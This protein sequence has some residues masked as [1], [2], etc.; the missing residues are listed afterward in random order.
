MLLRTV[1]GELDSMQLW[2]E[3]VL[4]I[5]VAHWDS[6]AD[7]FDAYAEGAIEAWH[8]SGQY[9]WMREA[10]TLGALV[11]TLA[12]VLREDYRDAVRTLRADGDDIPRGVTG[13]VSPGFA[14]AVV[15]AEITRRA[16]YQRARN[17]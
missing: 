17:S 16:L 15:R 1:V 12:H 4:A 3:D 8:A 14:R 9:T 7:V 13:E 2:L 5:G 6:D 10:R 11:N